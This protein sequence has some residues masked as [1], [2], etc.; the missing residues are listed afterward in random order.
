MGPDGVAGVISSTRTQQEEVSFVA[1]P[2][3]ATAMVRAH[4]DSQQPNSYLLEIEVNPAGSGIGG[5]SWKQPIEKSAASVLA[6]ELAKVHGTFQVGPT[7]DD[8]NGNPDV[9]I[10]FGQKELLVQHTAF[11]PSELRVALAHK[12][13]TAFT[14]TGSDLRA[15]LSKRLDAKRRDA[16]PDRTLVLDAGFC[17]PSSP[18]T[19]EIARDLVAADSGSWESIWLLFRLDRLILKL[20]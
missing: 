18:I 15:W 9:K 14:Y 5:R 7:E 12:E 2:N 20:R 16:K 13:A 10:E 4:T 3:G 19:L 8:A 17:I 1:L 6:A 11:E